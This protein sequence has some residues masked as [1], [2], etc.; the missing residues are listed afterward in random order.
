MIE[1]YGK[2]N[3]LMRRLSNRI[4]SAISYLTSNPEQEQQ[5]VEM[6]PTSA[7]K[8]YS[9]TSQLSVK[10]LNAQIQNKRNSLAIFANPNLVDSN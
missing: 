3:N 10:Q 9:T 1:S 5:Q 4:S 7:A 8:R 6:S 2:N